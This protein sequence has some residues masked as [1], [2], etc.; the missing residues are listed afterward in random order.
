MRLRS[1]QRRR[2]LCSP[3]CRVHFPKCIV[4]NEAAGINGH[5]FQ[6]ED[7]MQERRCWLKMAENAGCAG[8]VTLVVL[9]SAS[10]SEARM[11]SAA[12]CVAQGGMTMI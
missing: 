4:P 5:L 2:P 6:L 9:I 1:R 7:F 11:L 12:G 3:L 10:L 8:T